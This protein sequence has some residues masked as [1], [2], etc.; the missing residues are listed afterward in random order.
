MEEDTRQW[1]DLS[2]SRIGRINMVT[3]A[4]VP[5]AIYRFHII[6]IKFPMSFFMEI[7]KSIL[8]SHGS[9]KDPKQQKQY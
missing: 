5:K 9:T 4:I 2:C 7:E 8:N 1:K 3:M 6:P